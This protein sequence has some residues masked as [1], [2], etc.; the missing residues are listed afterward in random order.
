M[1]ENQAIFFKLRIFSS[2]KLNYSR[3]IT[4][5]LHTIILQEVDGFGWLGLCLECKS[6]YFN[7]LRKLICK[8][9]IHIHEHSNTLLLPVTLVRK[10]ENVGR[11]LD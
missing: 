11:L 8:A 10:I 3:D 1:G 4:Q 7:F 6:H 2:V 9:P 5:I